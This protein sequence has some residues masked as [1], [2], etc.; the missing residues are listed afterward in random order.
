MSWYDIILKYEDKTF[1]Y[2]IFFLSLIIPGVGYLFIFK[3]EIF[4]NIE[5][6]KFVLTAIFLSLPILLCGLIYVLLPLGKQRPF[7][8]KKN[9][10]EKYRWLI[11]SIALFTLVSFFLTLAG[12]Y[13]FPTFKQS[14]IYIV[15]AG[16]IILKLVRIGYRT[17]VPKKNKK[18]R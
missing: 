17:L 3:N 18:R 14:W 13:I 7:F 5:F 9:N 6:G 2:T 4:N 11:K 16:L 10:N 8:N 15:P 1:A 12:Y